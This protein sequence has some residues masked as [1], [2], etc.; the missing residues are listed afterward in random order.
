MRKKL[1][2]ISAWRDLETYEVAD[3]YDRKSKPH[4]SPENFNTL[5]ESHNNL[6]SVVQMLCRKLKVN[7]MWE[8]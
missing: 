6:I 4:A 2:E 8:I 3:G 5:L 1:E 7:P